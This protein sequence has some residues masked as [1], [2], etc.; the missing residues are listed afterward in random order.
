MSARRDRTSL[1][2]AALAVL[3][4]ALGA[5]GDGGEVDR[6]LEG[7][8]ARVKALR[9]FTCRFRQEK[10]LSFLRR[11][12]VSTGTIA[13]RDRRLLWRTETPSPGFLSV[14]AAEVRI[15]TPEF[16]TLEV[17]PLGAGAGGAALQGAFPGFTGDFAQLRE[18]Y[19]AELLP[20][21]AGSR[22]R[23]LRFTPRGEELKRE[24]ASVDVTLDE[25]LSVEA[26]R[27]VRANGDEL[28]LSI[29]DFV[30]NA[31]VKDSDLAFEVP[32]DAKVVK[33]LSK[34]AP[35]AGGGR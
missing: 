28:S 35:G 11:P 3:L 30:P 29:L 25:A 18:Q 12:L 21:A 6:V 14:D 27:I 2:S 1:R 10:K 4:A 31:E 9:S 19:A 26:W 32:A 22:D 7:W 34:P 13:Y 16:K 24:I 17:V 33:P 8:E 20:A 5:A 15:Y 23:T